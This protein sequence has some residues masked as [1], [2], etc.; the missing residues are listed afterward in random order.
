MKTQVFIMYIRFL[1]TKVV[2]IIVSALVG[3]LIMLFVS[4]Y[5]LKPKYLAS[6]TTYI[7]VM[8]YDNE[9]IMGYREMR[10]SYELAESFVL[11]I[12]EPFLVK[13][14]Y[15]NLPAGLSREYSLNEINSI[16]NVRIKP[17]TCVLEYTAV[18]DNKEDAI[19]LCNFYAKY[20][21]KMIISYL[22]VGFYDVLSSALP[23]ETV[24][25]RDKGLY[26]GMGAAF[27]AIISLTVLIIF[28]Y[29]DRRIYT[30]DK[31]KSEFDEI[32]VLGMIIV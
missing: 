2:Y 6:C 31:L 12:K 5:I 28:R 30:V 29:F 18:T 16:I 25:V 15:K 1:K 3:F 17:G 26:C 22:G 8:L 9:I 27:G 11:Y 13:S 32:K 24:N 7:T 23:E 20:S 19:L 14:A 10:A 21:L 4:Y